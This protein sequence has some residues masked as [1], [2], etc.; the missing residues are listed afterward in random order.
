MDTFNFRV[1]DFGRTDCGA[2]HGWAPNI[3]IL[4]IFASLREIFGLRIS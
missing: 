1:F 3:N 2:G 4:A